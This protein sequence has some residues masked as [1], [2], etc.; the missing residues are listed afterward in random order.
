M[1]EEEAEIECPCDKC[2]LDQECCEFCEA[3][4]EYFADYTDDEYMNG[5]FEANP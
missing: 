5:E 4:E 3:A 1:H 2:P